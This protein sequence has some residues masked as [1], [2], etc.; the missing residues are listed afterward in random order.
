MSVLL[1]KYT[2]LKNISEAQNWQELAVLC[3]KGH[4]YQLC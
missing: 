2:C 3:E 4:F 1:P